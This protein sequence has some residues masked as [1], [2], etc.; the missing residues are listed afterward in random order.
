[1]EEK[2]DGFYAVC[3]NLDDMGVDEIIRINKKRW[4]I[5][6]CF[7]IMKTEFKAHPVYLQREDRIKAHFLT[8]FISLFVY[9]ILEKKLYEKYTVEEIITTLRDMNMH[10]PG[11][12][13]GYNPAYTRTDL[14]DDLH[15]ACGFRTDYEIITDINMKKVIRESKKR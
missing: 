9:R 15:A 1:E 13:L 4:E 5:E 11:D 10:R 3:T 7:R 6:E 8:C 14:T 2:Y 12:K